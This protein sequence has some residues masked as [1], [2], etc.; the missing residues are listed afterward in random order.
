[1][2]NI[3]K[4]Y[5]EYWDK[6]T[7][8]TEV[9]D[10]IDRFILQFIRMKESGWFSATGKEGLDKHA[11]YEIVIKWTLMNIHHISIKIGKNLI[12]GAFL[13]HILLK[14]IMMK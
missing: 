3:N 6:Y 13:K 1:M 12:F 4:Y 9:R 10:P 11:H 7:K 8:F 2:K 14:T 5:D